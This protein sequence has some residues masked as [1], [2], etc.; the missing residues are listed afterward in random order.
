MPALANAKHEAF[1]QAFVA[2]LSNKTQGK[3]TQAAAYLA[4]GYST[5]TKAAASQCAYR[6]LKFVDTVA[7]RVA[8][9]QQEQ[10]ARL[11]PKIDLSKERVGRRLD[12]A[13]RIAEEEGNASAIATSELGIAKVFGH[14][15]E[16]SEVKLSTDY[17]S[18]KTEQDIGRQLLQQVGFEQ[19]DA[20]SIERAVEANRLFVEQLMQ[21][22]DQ[23][24]TLE[25]DGPEDK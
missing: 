24:V 13:S 14:I 11:K 8:E 7:G 21:I 20:L 23:A 6:L 22:R 9:L 15:T 5:K 4:A 10:V 3:N 1:S 25:L 2:S 18:A 19:P 12:L 16:K 17:S